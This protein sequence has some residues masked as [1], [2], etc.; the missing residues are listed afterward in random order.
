MSVVIHRDTHDR[1]YGPR[2]VVERMPGNVTDP[3]VVRFVK[4]GTVSK[5]L[6]R[7]AKWSGDGWEQ[8]GRRWWPREPQVP[9]T[10]LAIVDRHMREVKG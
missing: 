2:W 8:N 1:V 5:L 6:D 3:Y 10:L 4:F 9:K 7:T